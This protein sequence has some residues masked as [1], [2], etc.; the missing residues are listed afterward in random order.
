MTIH[1]A[2]KRLSL[3]LALVLCLPLV[4]RA[5]DASRNAKAA[6]LVLML[7]SDRMVEQS[8]DAI[9]KQVSAAA[10]SVTGPDPSPER[11]AR[12]DTFEKNISQLLNQQL[13]W[14]ALQP[15][16]T[17]LYAK[18]F[19]EQQLDAY[20]AF[21]KTPAGTFLIEHLPTIDASISQI[22]RSR[23]EALRPQMNQMFVAFRKAQ[24]TGTP[25]S[26]APSSTAPAPAAPVIT[27]STAPA[28]VGTS[29]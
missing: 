4:A 24:D 10:V 16:L 6:Q 12:T 25:A 21:Y 18:T 22:A 9:M 26:A 23:L 5:D 2:L 1:I 17:D 14:K 27:P 3:L 20:L 28:P 15:T 29:K 7:H 13:S 8:L 11:K 19:T